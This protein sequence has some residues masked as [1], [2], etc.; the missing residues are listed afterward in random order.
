M[1]LICRTAVPFLILAKIWPHTGNGKIPAY[2]LKLPKDKMAG[3]AA[4]QQK[5]QQIFFRLTA[6][7]ADIP[8]WKLKKS[9]GVIILNAMSR[10]LWG[11]IQSG[12][13]FLL[14]NAFGRLKIVFPISSC[15]HDRWRLFPEK[16]S[17]SPGNGYNFSIGCYSIWQHECDVSV[18]L[19]QNHPLQIKSAREYLRL[20]KWSHYLPEVWHR[21]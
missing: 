13:A 20:E 12:F 17:D 16:Y 7:A 11:Y 14:Y 5:K 1:C 6:L 8:F 15:N 9:D 2:Q 10:P 4:E 21:A 19:F 18:H 3:K